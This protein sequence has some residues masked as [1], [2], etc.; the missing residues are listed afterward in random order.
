M[1]YHIFFAFFCNWKEGGAIN[2][3][4]LKRYYYKS[5]WEIKAQE[6]VVVSRWRYSAAA[7]QTTQARSSKDIYLTSCLFKL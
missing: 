6:V 7:A 5:I 1:T 4:S 2:E 3:M